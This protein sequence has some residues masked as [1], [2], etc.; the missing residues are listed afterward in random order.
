MTRK[1][2]ILIASGDPGMLQ[3]LAVMAVAVPADAS[4]AGTGAKTVRLAQTAQPDVIV[5]EL[6]LPDMAMTGGLG[7]RPSAM[8]DP[9]AG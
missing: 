2:R 6:P 7:E 8:K 1:T 5:M 4:V 3:K 9:W